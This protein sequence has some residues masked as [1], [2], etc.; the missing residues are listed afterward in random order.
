MRYCDI[1]GCHWC[2]CKA[3]R[4]GQV[5]SYKV[6]E[7]KSCRVAYKDYAHVLFGDEDIPPIRVSVFAYRSQCI[8]FMSQYIRL[9]VSVD[10]SVSMEILWLDS[11]DG[12]IGVMVQWRWNVRSRFSLDVLCQWTGPD[13]LWT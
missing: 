2:V 3:Q 4:E 10:L 5:Y 12:V 9:R 6:I 11:F 1:L 8:R 13:R 7:C